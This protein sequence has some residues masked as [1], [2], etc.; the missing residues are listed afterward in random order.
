VTFEIS[1]RQYAIVTD[2]GQWAVD[3]GALTIFIGGGQP[4]FTQG[5]SATVTIFGKRVILAD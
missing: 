2:Q 3:P 5:L 1:P 4:G